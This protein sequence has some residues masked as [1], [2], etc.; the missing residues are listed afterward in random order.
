MLPPVLEEYPD[1]GECTDFEECPDRKVGQGHRG[2]HLSGSGE[3]SGLRVDYKEPGDH[4]R[5]VE[6]DSQ[7]ESTPHEAAAE[8]LER[9]AT[10][11]HDC[12]EKSAT[13]D[14]CSD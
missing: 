9:S 11:D 12:T 10:D 4:Q 14:G 13:D 8:G 1:F 3:F 7:L 5:H 6:L 2:G